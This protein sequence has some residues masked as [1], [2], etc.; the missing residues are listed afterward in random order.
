MQYTSLNNIIKHSIL[1]SIKYDL[2]HGDTTLFNRL[3]ESLKIELIRSF[4][5]LPFKKS[6]VKAHNLS[7]SEDLLESTVKIKDHLGLSHLKFK[8]YST[9]EYQDLE[10]SVKEEVEHRFPIM[11][12]KLRQKKEDLQEKGTD[13]QLDK[14]EEAKKIFREGTKQTTNLGDFADGKEIHSL[15]LDLLSREDMP[16]EERLSIEKKI[17]ELI[18]KRPIIIGWPKRNDDRI[19]ALLRELQNL[20]KEIEEIDLSVEKTSLTID[21]LTK[22]IWKKREKEGISDSDFD[23]MF[24]DALGVKPDSALKKKGA[25]EEALDDRDTPSIEEEEEGDKFSD[26]EYLY[27]DDEVIQKKSYKILADLL[28]LDMEELIIERSD[29]QDEV[30]KLLEIRRITEVSIQAGE[31]ELD[32]MYLERNRARNAIFK[33]F[34]YRYGD[35]TDARVGLEL[36]SLED[37]ERWLTELHDTGRLANLNFNSLSSHVFNSPYNSLAE[38]SKFVF[39]QVMENN[40]FGLPLSSN[41]TYEI[42]LSHPDWSGLTL[43]TSLEGL[44]VFKTYQEMTDIIKLG[45][46]ITVS[47]GGYLLN[48]SISSLFKKLFVEKYSG[49]AL[50]S[51]VDTED[52]KVLLEDFEEDFIETSQDRE[53]Y[54]KFKETSGDDSREVWDMSFEDLEDKKSSG[55]IV[56]KLKSFLMKNLYNM[57]WYD[58]IR[59]FKEV[60]TSLKNV[61]NIKDSSITEDPNEPMFEGF[62]EVKHDYFDQRGIKVTLSQKL[63]AILRNLQDENL[64][65]GQFK[66][67]L[68]SKPEFQSVVVKYISKIVL[69]SEV[70][71]LDPSYVGM[72][73]TSYKDLS[74]EAKNDLKNKVSIKFLKALQESRLKVEGEYDFEKYEGDVYYDKFPEHSLSRPREERRILDPDLMVKLNL[75]MYEV[76]SMDEKGLRDLLIE[77]GELPVGSTK[78]PWEHLEK[79]GA[80]TKKYEKEGLDFS[81]IKELPEGNIVDKYLDSLLDTTKPAKNSLA[82]YVSEESKRTR[83]RIFG[84]DNAIKKRET[85]VGDTYL[86]VEKGLH[87]SLNHLGESFS[88]DEDLRSKDEDDHETK[89][90]LN[91]LDRVVDLHKYETPAM[92][93][94]RGAVHELLD[95]PDA[96][97]LLLNVKGFSDYGPKSL[98]N[99]V[100]ELYNNLPPSRRSVLRRNEALKLFVD[101]LKDKSYQASSSKELSQWLNHIDNPSNIGSHKEMFLKKNAINTLFSDNVIEEV[102][103]LVNEEVDKGIKEVVKSVSTMGKVPAGYL[104]LRRAYFKQV[105]SRNIVDALHRLNLDVIIGPDKVRKIVREYLV[106]PAAF[107][108]LTPGKFIFEFFA[109]PYLREY[110]KG[111][112]PA[113]AVK[114]QLQKEF[115]NGTLLDTHVILSME[116]HRDKLINKKLSGL[117]EEE[118]EAK[119]PEVEQEVEN[120][121]V[122][123]GDE[124]KAKLREKVRLKFEKRLKKAF[125]PEKFKNSVRG[126]FSKAMFFKA[127]APLFMVYSTKQKWVIG[128][129]GEMTRKLPDDTVY[130]VSKKSSGAVNYTEFLRADFAFRS[131]KKFIANDWRDY[132]EKVL[133]PALSTLLED[134]GDRLHIEDTLDLTS[135]FDFESFT[136]SLDEHEGRGQYQVVHSKIE[137]VVELQHSDPVRYKESLERLSDDEL[138]A[139]PEIGAK[140]DSF[141][142]VADRSTSNALMES[143]YKVY[144]WESRGFSGAAQEARQAVQDK[145]PDKD[146]GDIAVNEKKLSQLMEVNKEKLGK[147]ITPLKVRRNS[148]IRKLVESREAIPM[149][150][151]KGVDE[152][153]DSMRTEHPEEYEKNK[154]AILKY[155]GLLRELEQESWFEEYFYKNNKETVSGIVN[156]GIMEEQAN[157][158]FRSDIGDMEKG[159]V[160]ESLNRVKNQSWFKPMVN[161]SRRELVEK[162]VLDNITSNMPNTNRAYTA[163]LRKYEDVEWFEIE[164]KHAE[165]TVRDRLSKVKAVIY[166]DS[167]LKSSVIRDLKTFSSQ[168]WFADVANA[169]KQSSTVTSSVDLSR[170]RK[171]VKKLSLLDLVD[172]D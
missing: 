28:E 15:K 8:A 137:S 26:T 52:I 73:G 104:N 44:K 160:V 58:F 17:K 33:Y 43:G 135:L 170:L 88:L 30:R 146:P 12:E 144:L 72:D 130:S 42:V 155:E 10:E 171:M 87:E 172:I 127:I 129:N 166:N 41:E 99:V 98:R 90:V 111:N 5:S 142:E 93:S 36:E 158:E 113:D 149:Q 63:A 134:I 57:L 68:F 114:K 32:H 167:P 102:E 118:K 92:D 122:E 54:A 153:I 20:E 89:K 22:A 161:S 65:L 9:E 120:Y 59:T 3:D 109:A 71:D 40:F 148:R 141:H 115:D 25:D 165:K 64:S 117:T 76:N 51:I 29:S 80:V 70:K 94:L 156:S 108:K 143:L 49:R 79:I 91:T 55:E 100:I 169:I 6:V 123:R 121:M 147:N 66:E 75:T 106:S 45:Y 24:K 103:S 60:D 27:A 131:M 11:M 1:A 19:S 39:S 96:K 56:S 119:L 110:I 38:D 82:R 14:V 152:S 47:R 112:K 105:G 140:I 124:I 154:S 162:A 50:S 69:E 125:D 116:I 2:R 133:I 126:I 83:N 168:P 53:E 37:R 95:S 78:D 61:L 74:D 81:V 159:D 139:L 151:G 163:F 48:S 157:P 97:Q 23:E 46:M 164:L 16:E 136:D 13:F 62:I 4:R 145:H 35:D 85:S 77:S 107:S 18:N 31:K 86:D 21:S 34:K 67:G 7:V 128:E 84:W 150:E 132:S 101:K 138:D